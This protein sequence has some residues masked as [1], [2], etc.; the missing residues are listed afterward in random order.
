[1][2]STIEF[3]VNEVKDMDLLQCLRDAK[4][5]CEVVNLISLSGMHFAEHSSIL[6]GP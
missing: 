5:P 1:M 3:H 2:S 4:L 6:I